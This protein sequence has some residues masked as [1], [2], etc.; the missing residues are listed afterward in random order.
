MSILYSNNGGLLTGKSCSVLNSK[1]STGKASQG[2]RLEISLH[3]QL[4]Q[5]INLNRD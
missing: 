3:I 4:N 2:F 5:Y 1:S